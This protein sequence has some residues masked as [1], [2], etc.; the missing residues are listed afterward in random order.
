MLREKVCFSSPGGNQKERLYKMEKILSDV[1]VE[2]I[3][4]TALVLIMMILVDAVNILAKGKIQDFLKK[5]EGFPQYFT[6]SLIGSLPG[7]FGGFTNVSLYIHGLISFGALTG[8]MVAMSGDEAFVMLALFPEQ[9]V[10]LFGILFIL[11]IIAGFFTDLAVKK[12]KLKFCEDCAGLSAKEKQKD[13]RNYLR[14]Q[15][16]NHII[17]KHIRKTAVW[18][19]FALLVMEA[20]NLFINL[21]QFTSD[22]KLAF[23]FMGA[24]AGLIPESG[25]HL[26][27][28]TL[29]ARG[30]V[31]FSVLL[32]SSIVQDGH[33]MLALLPHS[34]K[35]VVRIK[36]INFLF[37]LT[38]GFIVYIAGF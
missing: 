29:F 26:L 28:V 25:P 6:A 33:G 21:E 38:I 2:T 4:I 7:C 3:K 15:V 20:A 23:L 10:L 18:T 13:F 34:V 32:T 11:G 24:I 31:P 14:E 17:K 12:Y 35:D 16:W 9:A 22:Y 27:F 1:F 30:M 19:F 36:I 5:R 37:G 8:S